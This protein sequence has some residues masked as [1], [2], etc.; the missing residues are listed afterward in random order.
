VCKGQ[1]GKERRQ[2]VSHPN[3]NHRS[4][5]GYKLAQTKE[6]RLFRKKARQLNEEALIEMEQHLSFQEFYTHPNDVR[7]GTINQQKASAGEM[8]R[9]F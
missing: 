8:E 5:D 6:R 3:Q 4:Q 7:R 1:R 2:R 9:I